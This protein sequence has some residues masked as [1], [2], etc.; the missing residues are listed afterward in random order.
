MAV[1][2]TKQTKEKKKMTTENRKRR[3]YEVVGELESGTQVC[4]QY[5]LPD[6]DRGSEVA[7]VMA[8]KV[9]AVAISEWYKRDKYQERMSEEKIL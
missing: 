9:V 1:K 6:G 7:M 5:V 3:T 2:Y 4:V 8:R